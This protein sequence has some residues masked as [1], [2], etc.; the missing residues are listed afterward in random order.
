MADG[1]ISE[2]L[3]MQRTLAEE[4]GWMDD[5]SPEY[6]P[7]SLLWSIEE[8]GEAIA[9]IKKK[10]G[11]AI[12]ENESVRAHFLEECADI[13]MYLFDVF[14]D[15][16][17]TA[18]EFTQ[19]YRTKF[20][21]NMG[22]TWSENSALYEKCRWKLVI[23]DDSVSIAESLPEF[24]DK[25]G[26]QTARGDGFAEIAERFGVAP[27]LTVVCAGTESVAAEA[28]R[29]GMTVLSV[30]KAPLEAPELQ[31]FLFAE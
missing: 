12:M 31:R 11:E 24:L 25:I 1:K 18:E 10:G 16:G 2:F 30:S 21:R 29:L 9:I 5:R 7:M 22:R 4:K 20:L 3:A 23:F 6:A 27:S 15:Y 28:K 26:V 13:F 8:I 17:V 19:A 14:L